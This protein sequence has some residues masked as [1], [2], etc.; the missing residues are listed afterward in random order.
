VGDPDSVTSRG[1][2]PLAEAAFRLDGRVAIVTG[3]SSGLGERFARVLA[4]AGARVVL[5]AR[6]LDRLERL[7]A[8]LDG[9]I[10][11]ACD[12]NRAADLELPVQR[13]IEACGRVD[14]LVN[15]AGVENIQPAL[16]EDPERFRLVLEVNLVAPFL[17]ARTAARN[18]LERGAGGSIVNVA[19][20]LG[21]VGVGRPPQAGYTAS[22]GGLVNLTRELSAQ[23]AS[24]GVRVN[25]IAPGF[26]ESEMTEELFANE[27]GPK[28]V[29]RH[30]PMRRHGDVHELD[31]ALLFL[32][33]DASSY[34][35]GHILAVDGGWTSI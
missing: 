27:R 21:L 7:A 34:V 30:T 29:A 18:M 8:E 3:A 20:M 13:A 10:P 16:E 1:T 33:S 22:K 24:S 17:L 25:A 31:G 35:T 19:S 6:R 12:L 23:W 5:T 28:W 2:A 4:A 32:A 14:V 15:N 26:F 9:A 11:V